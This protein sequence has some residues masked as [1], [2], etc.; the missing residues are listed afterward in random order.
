MV[1]VVR[2]G[3]DF[4]DQGHRQGQR[5]NQ[6]HII[7][8]HTYTPK[9]MYISSINFLHFTVFEIWPDKI[10]ARAN[11]KSR[12]HHDDAH[13]HHSQY[14]YQISTSYSLW[15]LRISADKILT[16]KVTTAKSNQGHT[17]TVHTY[18]PQPM[19]LSTHYSF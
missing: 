10:S 8:L 5:A 1:S 16:F 3:K 12:S 4:K 13:Q 19:S 6:G 11:V 15:F 17:M 9:L 7:I 14:P 2:S 18:T